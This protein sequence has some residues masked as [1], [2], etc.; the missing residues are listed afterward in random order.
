M[1][2]KAYNGMM[3][4][5]GIKYIQD[6]IV[7]RLPKFK[8][9]SENKL[10]KEYAKLLVDHADSN[11]SIKSQIDFD[12]INESDLKEKI[13]KIEITEDTTILSYIY[14]AS[15]ILSDGF[16]INDFMCHLNISL[17]VINN[18]K[19]L[20]YPNI[21]VSEHRNILL[22]FLEDWYCQ[23]QCDP[24]ERVSKRQWRQRK[25]DWYAFDET[26]GFSMKIKLFDPIS[27]SDS[28]NSNFRGEELINKILLHIP[29]DEKRIRRIARDAILT[30]KEQE[31]KDKGDQ[32]RIW[33]MMGELA[34]EDNTEIQDYINSNDIKLI[35]IDA[36]YIKNAKM[37]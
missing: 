28:L 34:K 7:A 22:E 36:E 12:A 15:K 19:I 14:Q 8:D 17:Q 2:L 3:S 16:F 11:I 6:E 10:A 4:R 30:K 33:N 27:I 20:I 31:F 29:S 24:D 21:I 1:S 35:K 26:R 25:R 9:A 32:I 37:L 13:N 18:R 5:K 23:N